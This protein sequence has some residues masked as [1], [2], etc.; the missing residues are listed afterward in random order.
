MRQSAAVRING[1][2][3]SFAGIYKRIAVYADKDALFEALEPVRVHKRFFAQRACQQPLKAGAGA[4][5]DE[6]T[7]LLQFCRLFV[8]LFVCTF[9]FFVV[10]LS[11]LGLFLS[12]TAD[13][14]EGR[15]KEIN[16]HTPFFDP[17]AGSDAAFKRPADESAPKSKQ[18]PRSS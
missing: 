6:F 9:A 1:F 12:S 16:R 4:P 3:K 10:D 5:W 18:Q 7:N 13:E 14:G 11:V 17:A 2:D 15:G 8:S